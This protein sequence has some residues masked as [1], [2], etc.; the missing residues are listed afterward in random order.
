MCM[1]FPHQAHGAG[2]VGVCEKIK[3]GN[4]ACA[5]QI[6][7]QRI[8]GYPDQDY[9]LAKIAGTFWETSK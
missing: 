8:K 1:M 9:L 7:K 6:S 3:R 5:L 4:A 2:N